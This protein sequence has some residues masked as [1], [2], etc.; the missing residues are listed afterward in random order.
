M[1]L[2]AADQ[3]VSKGSTFTVPVTVDNASELVGI[4]GQMNYNK[5]LLTLEKFEL[6]TFK[7]TSAHNTAT[8]GKVS[9]AGESKTSVG[10]DENTVIANMVFRA[11][12]DIKKNEKA[13]IAFENVQA[14][15]DGAA[16]EPAYSPIGTKN[17][18]IM[19]KKK[20]K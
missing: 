13:I 5:D 6:V 3:K 20:L 8:P 17:A 14:V 1:Q 2:S 19:I 10:T 9:F 16:G 12:A 18:T 7:E 15:T 4:E 11:K